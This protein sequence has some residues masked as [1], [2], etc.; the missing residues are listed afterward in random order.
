[1]RTLN[2]PVYHD[3]NRRVTTDEFQIICKSVM[4][5]HMKSF[6]TGQAFIKFVE[7]GILSNSE[8]STSAKALIC[9]SDF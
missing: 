2:K 3:C 9:A 7:D 6:T 4:V 8:M 1:M 5:V